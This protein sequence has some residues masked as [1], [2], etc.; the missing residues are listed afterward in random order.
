MCGAATLLAER[1]AGCQ[2]GRGGFAAVWGGDV[3]FS[4]VRAAA[5]NLRR[6]GP[7]LLA[8]WDATRLPLAADSVDRIVSNPPF[9]KQLSSPDAVVPLYHSMLREYDRVLRPGG[10]A[11]LIA[12]A[13][14]ALRSAA[15]AVGWKARRQLAIR[16]L[17]QPAIITVWHKP[18]P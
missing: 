16:V 8:R 12:S 1:L 9:G 18:Q 13:A 7:A 4:A 15:R 6:L 17:G 3:D 10:Q 14:A 5:V 2:Q 11:V